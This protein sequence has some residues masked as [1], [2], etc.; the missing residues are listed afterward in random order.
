MSNK[1]K[2]LNAPWDTSDSLGQARDMSEG[3][4]HGTSVG[5][6]G[7]ITPVGG[8][9]GCPAVCPSACPSA[10]TLV[11]MT[12][13]IAQTKRC[14]DCGADKVCSGFFPSKATSDG[15]HT[16]CIPCAKATW[17]AKSDERDARRANLPPRSK[18]ARTS[19]VQAT[20]TPEIIS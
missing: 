5:H 17:R 11:P 10:P 19:R 2:Q 6:S 4:G 13:A 14:A 7:G 9:P 12:V 1:I 18:P 16:S 20:A 15:L 8:N 3:V